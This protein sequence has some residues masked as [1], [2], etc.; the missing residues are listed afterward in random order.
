VTPLVLHIGY[1]KTATSTF[2]KWAFP[3]HSELNYLGKHI[4]SMRYV[5]EEFYGCITEIITSPSHLYRTQLGFRDAVNQLRQ[6]DARTTL[7]SSEN[8]LHPEA[9]DIRS[10]AERLYELFPDAKVIITIRE[11]ISLITSH[12]TNSG[13]Y[14]RYI[15]MVREAAPGQLSFP[16][17]SDEWMQLQMQNYGRSFLATLHFH[18]VWNVYR[19][20]F[21]DESV[22]LFAFEQLR[23]DPKA[24]CEGLAD[25]LGVDADE[26]ISLI[27]Q[28]QENA[29]DPEAQGQS[30]G[31][32]GVFSTD[33]RHKLQ[34]LYGA[35]N[36]RLALAS[37]LP[38]DQ[39]SY[40]LESQ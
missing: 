7:I 30:D 38:L 19:D 8:F 21:G 34:A 27:N 40:A 16:M 28:R 31:A 29:S 4:P 23:D 18:D 39:Y 20:I 22:G 15:W 3:Q 2:Q 24:Y 11:Q 33:Q 36:A 37:G 25:F 26:L 32:L 10:V 5:D 12:M 13:R 35:G 9:V 1:P 6:S 14:G 17:T